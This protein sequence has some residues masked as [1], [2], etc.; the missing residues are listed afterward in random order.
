MP[1]RYVIDKRRRLVISNASGSIT[2]AEAKAHQDG[3]LAEPHFSPDFNQF[4]DA[5]KLAI[6]DLSIDE[7]KT[8]A[9]R[10][11]FSGT[12]RRAWV[13]PDPAIYGM[14]R[15]IAAY[16]EMSS[17]VSQISVFRDVPSALRWLGIECVDL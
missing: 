6:L 9:R 4:L 15:L 17:A 8:I 10:P 11:V 12:S 5:T 1:F 13:S 2:F 7:A 16:N 14:G 3:L